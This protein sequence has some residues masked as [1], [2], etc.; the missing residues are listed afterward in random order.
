MVKQCLS[1][2]NCNRKSFNF[3]LINQ[4]Q[5]FEIQR[6]TPQYSLKKKTKYAPQFQF[7][8]VHIT[9]LQPKKPAF[10]SFQ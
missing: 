5:H 8:H 4:Q 10:P 9:Y 7:F 2:S 1:F 3:I 6:K